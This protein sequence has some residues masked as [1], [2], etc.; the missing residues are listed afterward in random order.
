M[1]DPIEAFLAG[2]TPKVQAFSQ[3]L[4]AMVKSAMPA[5]NEIL[6]ASQNHIG[7]ILGE[8]MRNRVCY[9]CPLKD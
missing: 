2:Y 7:Y 5:A 6:F 8:S 1:L 9:I 4:R 3:T